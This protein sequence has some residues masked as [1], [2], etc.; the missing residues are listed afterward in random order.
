[1]DG[2]LAKATHVWS[3]VESGILGR[4]KNWMPIPDR[5][6]KYVIGTSTNGALV[7]DIRHN[8]G[9][10]ICDYDAD[11]LYRGNT[12]LLKDNSRN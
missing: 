5:P 1:M 7:Y 4:H 10:E 8:V 9:N 12:P 2:S 3:S 11:D 6:F